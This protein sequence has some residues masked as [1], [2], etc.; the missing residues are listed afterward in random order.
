MLKTRIRQK[1]P[2]S[3]QAVPQEVTAVECL[4][5]VAFLGRYKDQRIPDASFPLCGGIFCLLASLNELSL[6]R[7]NRLESF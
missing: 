1:G 7:T 4:H 3:L 2:A 5:P 6:S